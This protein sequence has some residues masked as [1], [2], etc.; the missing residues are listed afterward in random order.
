MADFPGLRWP[1]L[2]C[3]STFHP[4]SLG[5]VLRASRSLTS[6]AVGSGNIAPANTVQYLPFRLYEHATALSMS[7]IVGSTATGSADLGIYDFQGSRLVNSGGTPQGA[8]NTIQTL[9]LADTPLA[10]GVYYMA[11]TFSSGTSTFHRLNVN[12]EFMLSALPVLAETTGSAGLPATASF[13]T[14]PSIFV[15]PLMAV[16]FDALV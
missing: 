3:I 15:V 5:P 12:D 13:G 16:H 9:D 14:A 6:S 10:P 1:P 4:E 7:Y 11:L 8:V 2:N